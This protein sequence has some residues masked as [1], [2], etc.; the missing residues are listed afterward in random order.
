M[1]PGALDQRLTLEIPVEA[2]DGVGGTVRS[3]AAGPLLWASVTPV[4]ARGNLV[5]DAAGASVTHRIVIRARA[6]ITVRHRLR[7]G[8]RIWRIVAVRDE[9][10]GRFLRIEAEER[11]D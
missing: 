1:N 6:D 5:A 4:A 3:Y 8:A 7:K 2:A 11:R 10:A 9:D